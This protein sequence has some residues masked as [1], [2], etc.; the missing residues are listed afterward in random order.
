MSGKAII[1]V[2][3]AEYLLSGQYTD[4]NGSTFQEL[5][6]RIERL[7]GGTESLTQR[8]D[9]LIDGHDGVLVV[10]PSEL[11]SAAVAFIPEEHFVH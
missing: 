3:G 9:V 6:S 4:A 8:F 7:V 10:R 5:V 1:H 2:N 11:N